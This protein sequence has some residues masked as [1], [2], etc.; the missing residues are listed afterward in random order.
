MADPTRI[1]IEVHSR[2][3]AT[4]AAN[5]TGDLSPEKIILQ[6]AAQVEKAG[7][8]P[9]AFSMGVPGMAPGSIDIRQFDRHG[10]SLDK[11]SFHVAVKSDDSASLTI[12][13]DNGRTWVLVG[14]FVDKRW[15]EA[16]GD[17]WKTGALNVDFAKLQKAA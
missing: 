14:I 17:L 8:V 11:R 16:F 3:T 2:K 4:I 15:A 7:E 9:Y 6:L 10:R 1:E 13:Q 5:V 12:S